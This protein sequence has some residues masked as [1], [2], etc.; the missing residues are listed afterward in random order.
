MGAGNISGKIVASLR[1]LGHI[2]KPV[3]AISGSVAKVNRCKLDTMGI[4]S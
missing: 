2:V 3:L 4:I 1:V